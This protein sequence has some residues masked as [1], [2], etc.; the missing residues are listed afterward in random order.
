MIFNGLIAS[1][2]PRMVGEAISKNFL[3]DDETPVS[4]VKNFKIFDKII[5]LT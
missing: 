1:E 3:L 4:V 5:Q 2:K